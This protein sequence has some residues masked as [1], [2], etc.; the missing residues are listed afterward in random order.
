MTV[1][2]WQEIPEPIQAE[3]DDVVIGAGIVGSY[4]AT[5]LRER[6][7]D[8]ALVDARFPAAGASGRNAGFVLTAQR[9]TYPEL[10]RQVG[11]EAAREILAMVRDNVTRM[12]TLAKGFN[13]PLE[14]GAI[15]LAETAAE[16]RELEHWAREL[17]ADGTTV[18]FAHRDPYGTGYAAMMQVENDCMV[19]PARLTE[20]IAAASG[21]TLYDHNEVYA[22]EPASDHLIVRG[23]RVHIRCRQVYIATNG[24]S[25]DLHPYLRRIVRPVRGQIL[26]TTPV[27]CIL[28]VAGITENHYFRQLP[29]GRLLIGGARA[30]FEAQEYTAEDTVTPNLHVNLANYL[31]HWFPDV[32]FEIERQWAGIHGFTPD[33]RVAIGFIPN[34]KRIAFAVGF[35][36]YGN[37]I[38]LVAAERMVELAM[39]DRDAGPLS[40]LRFP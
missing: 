15:H 25:A 19:H 12:R 9:E 3:H 28:S 24:Y 32:E 6:G 23:R 16:A 31:R 7:R 33:R 4:T 14:E 29:D 39:D 1:S 8:V 27:Q 10:I 5:C 20:A 21:V 13:V 35:S 22:I 17:E 37:S 36:G 38:G 26:V 18:E 40:A 2:V 34:E 30:F 11:R